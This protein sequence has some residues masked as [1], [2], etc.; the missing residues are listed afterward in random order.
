MS[1]QALSASTVQLLGSSMNIVSP[2]DLVKELIDNA[3]DAK[4]T[5]IDITISS[6]TLDRVT[7]KDN[8]TG[9]DID[10]FNSANA[11]S[12]IVIITKKSGNPVAW[13]IELAHAVGGVKAKQPVSA[14]VGTTVAATRLFENMPPRKQYILKE[15][16]RTMLKI[17]NT[18]KAYALARPH[19]KWSLKMVGNTKPMWSYSPA[20]AA[21]GREA[22]LQ[23]F[24]SNLLKNCTEINEEIPQRCNLNMGDSSKSSAW[25][26][27]G[28]V[29][30]QHSTHFNSQAVFISIDGRPMSSSWHIS[31]AF[32]SILKSYV[33]GTEEQSKTSLFKG[34]LFAQL[35]VQC[36]PRSYDPNIT[37]QKDEV[38]FADENFLLEKLDMICR[39]KLKHD[40]RCHPTVAPST[41]P[42]RDTSGT[43]KKQPLPE[44][45]VEVKGDPSPPCK[46]KN[47]EAEGQNLVGQEKHHHVDLT[48]TKRSAIK[49]VLKTSFTVNMSNR[50]DDQSDDED[51]LEAIEVEIPRRPTPVQVGDHS[52]KDNIRHYFH[53]V[54][55]Q[56]FDIACDSTAATTD[57]LEAEEE[58]Q[59]AD[60]HSAGRTP[61]RPLTASDLNRMRDEAESSPE[62]QPGSTSMIP[63]IERPES[64]LSSSIGA[65]SSPGFNNV[66]RRE[67]W[68][69][70]LGRSSQQLTAPTRSIRV[71]QEA[72]VDPPFVG[73]SQ[74]ILTP[75]PSDPRYRLDP[76]SPPLG[77]RLRS[78][79]AS[80]TR[81]SITNRFNNHRTA[82]ANVSSSSKRSGGLLS[83]STGYNGHQDTFAAAR[84]R[85]NGS[86]P[87]ARGK[88]RG[89]IT[90]VA[91]K[92]C[93]KVASRNMALLGRP[94]E[95]TMAPFQPLSFSDSLPE[96]LPES[97]SMLAKKAAHE[98]PSAPVGYSHAL[99]INLARTPAPMSRLDANTGNAWT[100]GLEDTELKGTKSQ[101]RVADAASPFGLPDADGCCS[102]SLVSFDKRSSPER[103]GISR[104]EVSG[105]L[106]FQSQGMA[107]AHCLC[108]TIECGHG[109]IERLVRQHAK[110]D[111]YELP[112]D[113]AVTLLSANLG[114]VQSVQKRLQLCVDSWMQQNKIRSQVDYMM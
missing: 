60:P 3:I 113:I 50:E 9:I 102:S 25:I 4:A 88:G 8:G 53:P 66:T 114:S 51:I 46:N 63:H 78:L 21:S 105:G 101:N 16:N 43:G 14:T 33:I 11:L 77:S 6:N 17:Q 94:A 75:P 91:E 109:D 85:G 74:L 2:C 20:R 104:S 47:N 103:N 38:L 86:G 90:H 87:S 32:A 36:P 39:K 97:T 22:I 52:R 106:L 81:T 111:Q 76:E 42:G 73:H 37:A 13:R 55:T 19:I 40:L 83:G 71:N 107:N 72:A 59:L 65:A 1:I 31:K 28:Y 93:Y 84:L 12:N 30:A 82:L 112:G 44:V 54:P 70:G 48:A 7:V 10:D 23:F 29:G 41:G 61:L 15:K 89:R 64:S 24:G 80:P 35:N 98:I 45:E 95:K 79:D 108:T 49:T 92:P 34:H 5:A 99:Q 67:P 96:S 110:V 56:D 57:T 58:K 68:T 18:V 26:F 100:R 69:G 27:T 62:Q